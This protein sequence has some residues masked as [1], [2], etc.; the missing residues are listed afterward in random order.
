MC[1]PS[2]NPS[3]THLLPVTQKAQTSTGIS[4]HISDETEK[5][6]TST[7]NAMQLHLFSLK[8]KLIRSHGCLAQVI[9]FRL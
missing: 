9:Q 5:A 2:L 8:N 7:G 1:R 4:S 6:Q 3:S